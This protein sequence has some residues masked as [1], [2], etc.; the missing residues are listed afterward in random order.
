[1]VKNPGNTVKKLVQTIYQPI[2]W[3]ILAILS[4]FL[5]KY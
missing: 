3:Q 1:M 4:L 2:F 5:A